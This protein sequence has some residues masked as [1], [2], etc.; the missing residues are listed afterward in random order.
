ML[1]FGVRSAL[2]D[3]VGNVLEIDVLGVADGTNDGDVL[4]LA[5]GDSVGF[6][7]G[8][9]LGEVEGSGVL[10]PLKVTKPIQKRSVESP[11]TNLKRICEMGL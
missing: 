7:D 4:G 9:R 1:G 5:L 10:V 2:G 3:A 6:A 11:A 8:E